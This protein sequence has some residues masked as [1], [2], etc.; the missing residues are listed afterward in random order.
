MSNP[1][2]QLQ[3]KKCPVCGRG[4]IFRDCWAYKKTYGDHVTNYCSWSCMRK[5]EAEEERK[6]KKTTK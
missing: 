2:K 5:A 6:K 3:E 1:K 4:Y